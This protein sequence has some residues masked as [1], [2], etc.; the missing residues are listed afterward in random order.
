[1]SKPIE[2]KSGSTT[3]KIYRS[4]REKAGKRYTQF[5]VADHRSGKRKLIAFADEK[6]ARAKAD[7]ILLTY[8]Q[9]DQFDRT[10]TRREAESYRSA[11]EKLPLGKD[12]VVVVSE[13]AE[14]YSKLGGRSLIEA[15]NDFVRRHPTTRPRKTVSDVLAELIAAKTADGVSD[16]YLKDLR[17]RLGQFGKSFQ[18]Q[19]ADVDTG[20]VNDFLRAL[21]KRRGS[22]GPL[23]PRGRNNY[24]LAIVTLFKFAASA[25]YIPSD[26]LDYEKIARARE[27]HAQIE[28]FTPLEIA[29][30]INAAR[31]DPDNLKAG[32]N[33]RYATGPGLLPLLVLG[34]FAGMRT[35]EIERQKWEDINLE[36]GHIRVTAAKGNTAA[37]RLIPITPNLKQWLSL[38]RRDAGLVCDIARTADAINRLAIRAGVEW[39]HN[40]LRHSFASYRLAD[41]KSAAQVSLEMGN[42]PKMVFKHYRELVT[43][44][45]ATTWFSISPA[46]PANVAQIVE[47][48]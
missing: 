6:D 34:A 46:T 44:D 30:L 41:V 26:Q 4:V 25:G 33:R 48:A 16:V 2:I 19:I 7:E 42:S 31:L 3:V 1:M 43:S 22:P 12:L 9:P 20:K 39:K 45:E 28:I 11:V 23:D 17:F 13:Y 38:F 47:V 21:K 8:T 24:R 36:R 15:V 5:D 35:A 40:A 37:K 10:L 27:D 14:A 32:F 29:K 18:C